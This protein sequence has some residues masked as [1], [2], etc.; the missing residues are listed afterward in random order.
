MFSDEKKILLVYNNIK[1]Y[2]NQTAKTN[3]SMWMRVNNK[4]CAKCYT[5]NKILI[6]NKNMCLYINVRKNYFGS[7]ADK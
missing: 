5:D 6:E 1:F 7:A 3:I 2:K 4:C